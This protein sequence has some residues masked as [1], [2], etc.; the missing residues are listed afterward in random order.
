VAA[1]MG[2]VNGFPGNVYRITVYVPQFSVVYP[3]SDVVIKVNGVSS[4]SSVYL[5][6]GQ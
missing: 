4:E 6:L 1:L 5:S 2:P 3:L